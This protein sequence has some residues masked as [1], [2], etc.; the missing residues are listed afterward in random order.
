MATRRPWPRYGQLHAP[1][2]PAAGRHG[3]EHGAL[4]ELLHCLWYDAGEG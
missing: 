3:D 4:F 2:A 1:L